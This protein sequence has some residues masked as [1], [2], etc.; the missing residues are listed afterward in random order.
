VVILGSCWANQG[1]WTLG[2]LE[3]S[4]GQ[5]LTKYHKEAVHENEILTRNENA[6]AD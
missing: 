3:T 6:V 4:D 1:D 2:T 5:T